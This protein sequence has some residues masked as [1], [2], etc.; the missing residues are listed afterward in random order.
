MCVLYEVDLMSLTMWLL[1]LVRLQF[2]LRTPGAAFFNPLQSCAF[3]CSSFQTQATVSSEQGNPQDHL[4]HQQLE[5]LFLF[6]WVAG[7]GGAG[8]V[9]PAVGWM[10][11]WMVRRCPC[12]FKPHCDGIQSLMDW[13][14]VRD[15]GKYSV[16][17]A[18]KKTGGGAL[19][20]LLV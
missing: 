15:G 14:R 16:E 18:G 13:G 11:G 6:L 4:H 19:Q 8:G 1:R 20:F 10:D 5:L 17:A 7:S 3:C 12:L 2:Y 9:R